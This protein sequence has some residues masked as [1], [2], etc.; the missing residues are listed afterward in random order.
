MRT[1]EGKVK[2]AVVKQIKALG[3]YYFFP[4][5]GGFGVSGTPDIVGCINGR[6]F[7]F[8]CKAGKNKPTALQEKA[9]RN[10]NESGGVAVV[11]NEQ[12]VHEVTDILLGLKHATQAGS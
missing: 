1:P 9:I 7:A 12:N 2:D 3:A 10:I 4:I 6:F 5:S 11:I 8:E